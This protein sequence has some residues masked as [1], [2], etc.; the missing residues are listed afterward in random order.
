MKRTKL[1]IIIIATLFNYS[2]VLPQMRVGL[3]GSSVIPTGYFEDAVDVG[4]GTSF[5]FNYSVFSNFE[6][7]ISSGYFNCGYKENLE[8]YSFKFQTIPLLIG[9]KLDLTDFDFIPYIGIEGGI[10]F[11]KYVLDINDFS[12]GKISVTT[13]DKHLGVAPQVGFRMNISD[14]FDLDVCTKYNLLKNKYI[15]RSFIMIQTGFAYR[16]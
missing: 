7:T 11:S 3:F 9:A 5:N 8:D 4:Y 14:D 16:F 12:L 2:S 10:Y 15:A 13:N 1:I 6:I